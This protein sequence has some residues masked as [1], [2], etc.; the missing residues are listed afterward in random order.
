MEEAPLDEEE[1][2]LDDADSP[3]ALEEDYPLDE[4]EAQPLVDN[5]PDRRKLESADD[6]YSRAPAQE[7]P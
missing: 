2:P 1:E 5:Y 6:S 3:L 7:F 4:E